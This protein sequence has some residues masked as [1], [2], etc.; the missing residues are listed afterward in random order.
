[1]AD[2]VHKGKSAKEAN[3]RPF[4]CIC[5]DI[6]SGF[7]HNAQPLSNGRCC[8]QC[9]SEKVVPHRIRRMRQGKA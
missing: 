2:R 3:V 9:N 8:D 5:G 6:Y 4:C 1:M 7:G